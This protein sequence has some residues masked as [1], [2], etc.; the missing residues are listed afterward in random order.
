[1]NFLKEFSPS[2]KD[3]VLIYPI[4]QHLIKEAK[5]AHELYYLDR[6]KLFKEKITTEFIYLERNLRII[7]KDNSYKEFNTQ[8]FLRS[9]FSKSTL[10][11]WY[12]FFNE[13]YKE[14]NDPRF[15]KILNYILIKGYLLSLPMYQLEYIK[16]IRQEQIKLR[17]KEILNRTPIPS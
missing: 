4:I 11:H 15:E 12:L 13:R 14:T 16:K 2:Q 17:D 10:E 8:I 3:I 5:C 1:M 7:A 6:Y 9:A